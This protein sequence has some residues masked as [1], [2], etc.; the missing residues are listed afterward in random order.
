ML[1]AP[2]RILKYPSKTF[3]DSNRALKYPLRTFNKPI[4]VF[5]DHNT[6]FYDPSVTLE[7]AV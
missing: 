7:L 3:N 4:T 6:I 2:F 1:S 5:N